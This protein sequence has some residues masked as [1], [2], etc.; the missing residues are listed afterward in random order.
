MYWRL[1]AVRR[2]RFGYLLVLTLVNLSCSNGGWHIHEWIYIVSTNWTLISRNKETMIQSRVENK[3]KVDLGGDWGEVNVII[4]FC[5]K[6]S[7]DF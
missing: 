4:I 6:F 2:E 3:K 1:K 7:K 5:T